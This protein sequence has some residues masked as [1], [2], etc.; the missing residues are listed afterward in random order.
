VRILLVDDSRVMRQLVR[1]ALRQ[2]GHGHHAVEEAG[3]AREAFALVEASEPDLVLCDW[4]MPGTSGLDLL[5]RLRRVGC[6]V[7]FGLVTSEG[8]GAMRARA[9]AAGAAFLVAKPFTPDDFRVALAGLDA[10]GELP[11]A[12][13]PMADQQGAGRPDGLPHPYEVKAVL[14]RLLS[15]PVEL[16][17]GDPVAPS[18]GTVV[19]IYVDAR[20][21]M[22]ALVVADL[23]LAAHAG[24]AVGLLPP[25]GAAELVAGETL[26]APVLDNVAEVLNVCAGLLNAPPLPH[27]RLYATY[28]RGDRLPGDVAAR[29][30]GLG[31][32]LDLA[33]TVTGYGAG[34]L[35]F[36]RA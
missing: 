12:E 29:L 3:S 5:D 21:R 18:P 28:A 16:R 32:R 17:H 15:R 19:G 34:G 27:V 6:D 2:A 10:R 20:L 8:S 23:R 9:A 4:N 36:L 22:A 30:R 7:P 31:E 33:V 14:E 25:A 35:S 13:Q 26:S 11:V 24:A 1:R